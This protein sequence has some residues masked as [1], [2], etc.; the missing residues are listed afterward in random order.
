MYVLLVVF[1]ASMYFSMQ[2]ER[3]VCSLVE[4]DV[5]GLGIQ[6]AKQFL[7]FECQCWYMRGRRTWFEKLGAP[8]YGGAAFATDE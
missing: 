3:H 1:Q 4:R 8:M 5:E 6:V 7:G 2:E